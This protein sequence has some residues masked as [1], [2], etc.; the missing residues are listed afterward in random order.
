MRQVQRMKTFLN[1]MQKLNRLEERQ[2]VRREVRT[3]ELKQEIEKEAYM[4]ERQYG[5]P[6]GRAFRRK[7]TYC[8]LTENLC[9]KWWKICCPTVSVMPKSR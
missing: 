9:W 3:A 8:G 4:M 5:K 7:E 1:D 2:I 6:A